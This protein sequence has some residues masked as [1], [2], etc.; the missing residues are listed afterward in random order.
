MPWAWFRKSLE[1]ELQKRRDVDSRRRK[2]PR[3]L[4]TL[5]P[6]IQLRLPEK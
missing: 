1:K 6:A 2:R 5:L 4:G 3:S